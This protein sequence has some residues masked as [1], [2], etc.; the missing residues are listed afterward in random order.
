MTADTLKSN[1]IRVKLHF[2][3]FVN[4]PARYLKYCRSW[5]YFFVVP[6]LKHS[7]D[8]FRYLERFGSHRNTKDFCYLSFSM[9]Q[10]RSLNEF[11]T[12]GCVRTLFSTM[13]CRNV[14]FGTTDF[15]H[16]AKG[17]AIHKE[18]SLRVCYIGGG[19]ETEFFDF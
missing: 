8:L 3:N 11:S 5:F 19:Q 1:R 14:A 12:D 9:D 15:T 10:G 4:E 16:S 13:P 6:R 7:I 18:I 2:D 17:C